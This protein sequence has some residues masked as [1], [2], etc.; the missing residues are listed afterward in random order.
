MYM[1]QATVYVNGKQREQ[2]AAFN[3]AALMNLVLKAAMRIRAI[4]PGR[5]SITVK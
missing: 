5:I 1:L 2:I 3:R 4:E